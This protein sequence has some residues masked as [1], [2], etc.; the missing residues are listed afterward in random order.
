MVKYENS[1]IYKICCNN[2]E[3]KDIYIGSTTNFNMRKYKHK[4][5]C[6]DP[7]NIQSNEHKYCYIRENGGWNNWSMIEIKS[8][9]C[10]NKRELDKYEREIYEEYKPTLNTLRP[11]I[12]KEEKNLL[13][14]I[15]NKKCYKKK[16]EKKL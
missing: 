8:V 9:K 4:S 1:V 13:S 2:T 12:T 3:I 10:N 5:V 6:N 11:Y 16:K 15:N 14:N 7:D